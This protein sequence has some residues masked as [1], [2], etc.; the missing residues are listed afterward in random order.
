MAPLKK[1]AAREGRVIVFVD[2][3]SFSLLPGLVRTWAPRGQTPVLHASYRWDRLQ[4]ISAV[5]PQGQLFTT[6]Q[7]KSFK[8]PHLVRFVRHVWQQLQQ[9]LLVIW[10]G[11]P[12]HR[13]KS[14]QRFLESEAKDQIVI[15]QLPGYAPEL[16][17][18]EGVWKQL[19]FQELK[20]LCCRNLEQLRQELRLAIERLRHKK[21]VLRACFH[22]AG[23]V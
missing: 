15:E 21:P 4:V 23:L 2:E 6:V 16:N 5:T 3:A 10:D 13:E 9:P 14:V 17:P 22:Q 18:D 7:D 20:N 1:K 12:A 8:G 11:L 19:K